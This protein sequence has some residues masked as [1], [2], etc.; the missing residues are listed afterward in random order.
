MTG[1]IANADDATGSTVMRHVMVHKIL[2]TCG[3]LSSLLYVA[4][5]ILAAMVWEGYDSIVQPVSELGA[6]DAPS[7]PVMLLLGTIYDLL[8][9][10]FGIGVWRILPMASVRYAA[11]QD[12]CSAM[13]PLA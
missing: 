3:I 12:C 11:W 6:I 2:L 9:I 1:L 5:T 13:E 7:Q 10:A 4:A 8:V